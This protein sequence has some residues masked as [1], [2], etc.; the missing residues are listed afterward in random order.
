[1]I[2]AKQKREELNESNYITTTTYKLINQTK[3]R[4]HYVLLYQVQIII[5]KLNKILIYIY[6]ESS[7]CNLA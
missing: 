7:L 6:S 2:I 5:Y 3:L 1:M 4:R